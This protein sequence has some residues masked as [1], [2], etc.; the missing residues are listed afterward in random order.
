MAAATQTA[1]SAKKGDT[2]RCEK[3]GMEVKLT[4]DCGSSS[5]PDFRCCNQ[6]LK[7]V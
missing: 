7:K 2:Y 3:C 4:T 1:K 5:G 6:P